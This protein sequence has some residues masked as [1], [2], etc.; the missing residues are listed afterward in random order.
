M[1]SIRY[2]LLAYCV[3]IDRNQNGVT[4]PLIPRI[5]YKYHILNIDKMDNV[6]K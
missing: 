5:L 2:L 6:F 4:K 3:L 1:D